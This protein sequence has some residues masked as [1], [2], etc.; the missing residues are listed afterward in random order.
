MKTYERN[1]SS[2]IRYVVTSGPTSEDLVEETVFF[3]SI[4]EVGVLRVGTL[5]LRLYEIPRIIDW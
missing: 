1:G 3:T 2:G 4:I 5:Y